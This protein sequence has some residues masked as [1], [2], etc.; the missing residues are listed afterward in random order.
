[1]DTFAIAL[2]LLLGLVVSCLAPA[3]SIAADWIVDRSYYT[4]DPQTA[5]RVNQYSP[6]GP[7]YIFPRGDYQESGYH[8]Y[9]SSIAVGGSADHY[10]V[11]RE[12]GRPVRPYGEWQH[13]YR[14]YSVPY[15]MW[16]A[17]FDGLNLN[18]GPQPYAPRLPV[19]F[20]APRE[21]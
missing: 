11:V 17:P 7:F 14:P 6:I 15:S 18:I 12:Y 4:H 2:A 9:Q 10:H 19:P 13:P 5:E 20:E 8:H 16:G 1:M 3:K 21:Y